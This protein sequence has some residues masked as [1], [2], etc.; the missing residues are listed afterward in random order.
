MRNAENKKRRGRV[1]AIESDSFQARGGARV[2]LH[3]NNIDFHE[4]SYQE[5]EMQNM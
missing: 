1:H 5:Y 3:E 4:V 2:K